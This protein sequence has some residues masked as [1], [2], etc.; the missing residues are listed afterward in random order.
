MEME[1]GDGK[2]QFKMAIANVMKFNSLNWNRSHVTDDVILADLKILSKGR[3]ELEGVTELMAVKPLQV[4]NKFEDFDSFNAGL[5][6]KKNKN[7]IKNKNR[8]KGFR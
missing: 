5:R 7:K 2:E 6:K 4:K 1:E 8:N 3:L